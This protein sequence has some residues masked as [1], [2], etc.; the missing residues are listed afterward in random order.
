MCVDRS[1]SVS[2]LYAAAAM[3]LPVVR[4]LQPR[5]RHDRVRQHRVP[6][7]DRRRQPADRTARPLHPPADDRRRRDADERGRGRIVVRLDPAAA[8]GLV[9]VERQRGP[10][11]AGGADDRLVRAERRRHR[12]AARRLLLALSAPLRR[13]VRPRA[14]AGDRLGRARHVGGV[15]RRQPVLLRRQGGGRHGADRRRGCHVRR[16]RVRPGAPRTRVRREG[17]RLEIEGP[18]DRAD[19]RAPGR[20]RRTR[21]VAD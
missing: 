2:G 1:Q 9:V 4:G 17:R 13:L 14:G 18:R 8:A 16:A 21:R 15:P 11:P 10:R 19:R 6:S 5:H 12:H 20:Q 7:V 3:C